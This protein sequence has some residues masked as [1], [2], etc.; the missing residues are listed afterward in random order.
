MDKAIL[1]GTKDEPRLILELQELC[2]S[3]GIETI[4]TFEVNITKPTAAWL[5]GSG[6]AE[7]IIETALD[8]E[9]DMIVFNQELSPSQQRNWERASGLCVIDRQEVILE[10]FAQRASTREAAL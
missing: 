3:I 6:K 1:V 10:I 8:F 9:A 5:I 4:T 7:E 2:D